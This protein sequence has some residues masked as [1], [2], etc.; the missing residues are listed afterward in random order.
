MSCL[1]DTTFALSGGTSKRKVLSI[2]A[3]KT[4]RSMEMM[5]RPEA[6]GES[7][8]GSREEGTKLSLPDVVPAQFAV[9]TGGYRDH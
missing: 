4:W 3:L 9:T 5:L 6:A 1:P 2:Q 7:G 8:Q